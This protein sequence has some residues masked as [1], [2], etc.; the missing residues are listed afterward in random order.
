MGENKNQIYVRKI[1]GNLEKRY[2]YYKE[3]SIYSNL[4]N[5]LNYLSKYKINNSSNIAD[6]FIIRLNLLKKEQLYEIKSIK[7]SINY[8]KRK[9]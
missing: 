9:Y 3:S 6:D 7:N 5:C 1:R 4:I 2:K 8:I